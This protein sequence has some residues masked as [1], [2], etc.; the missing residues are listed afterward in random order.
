MLVARLY[1]IMNDIDM[2]RR[3]VV[4][5]AGLSLSHS[6]HGNVKKVAGC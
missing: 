1:E 4:A 2:N 5:M 3:N 6:Y